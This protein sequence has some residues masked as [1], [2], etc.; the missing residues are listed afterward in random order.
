MDKRRAVEI[1]NGD[2]EI[3]LAGEHST[4]VRVCH[5]HECVC[6]LLVGPDPKWRDVAAYVG[7][8]TGIPWPKAGVTE[9]RICHALTQLFTADARRPPVLTALAA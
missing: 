6:V 4:A 1:A 8:R 7:T 9:A 3:R 2:R 5:T